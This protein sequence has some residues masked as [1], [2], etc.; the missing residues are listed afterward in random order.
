MPE[1]L[2]QCNFGYYYIIMSQFICVAVAPFV[3]FF[4]L[5]LY[6]QIELI[7]AS[8]ICRT[9]RTGRLT[10]VPGAGAKNCGHIGCLQGVDEFPS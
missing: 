1:K 9:T 10:T 8:K 4:T 3:S 7:Q 6:L 2:K 5:I